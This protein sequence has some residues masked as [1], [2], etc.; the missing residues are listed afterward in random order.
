[1]DNTAPNAF[2]EQGETRLI[3]AVRPQMTQSLSYWPPGHT[4][5]TGK[6]KLPPDKSRRRI[7]GLKF[8]LIPR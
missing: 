4:S 5:K 3:N 8:A 2:D 7:L 6:D 1:M